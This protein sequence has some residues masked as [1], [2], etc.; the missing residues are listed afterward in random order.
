MDRRFI[1]RHIDWQQLFEL[2]LASTPAYAAPSGAMP[3]FISEVYPDDR[4]N[5]QT[6]D[7]AGGADLFEYVE[8]YNHSGRRSRLMTS[9]TFVTTIIRA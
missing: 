9:S 4:S 7:G 1:I 8:I 2:A 3:V 6:I 5:Q